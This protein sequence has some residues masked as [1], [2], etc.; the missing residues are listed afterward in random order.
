MVIKGED[1]KIVVIVTTGRFQN[2]STETYCPV[3]TGLTVLN[4]SPSAS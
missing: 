1:Y 2:R 3:T 4:Q